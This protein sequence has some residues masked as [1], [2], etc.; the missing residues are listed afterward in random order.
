MYRRCKVMEN[1]QQLRFLTKGTI[2][3]SSHDHFIQLDGKKFRSS[4]L[5][6]MESEVT[7]MCSVDDKKGFHPPH[8]QVSLHVY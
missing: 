3:S 8:I 2:M 1:S 7:E 6:L 5:Y 4:L